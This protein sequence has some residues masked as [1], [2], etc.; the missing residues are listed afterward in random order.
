M[1]DQALRP[2]EAATTFV[3]V[4]RR[5]KAILIGS[6]GNL[7]EWYDFYSYTAFALY[8]A[9]AFFPNSDPVVQQLNAAVLFAATFLMRPLG[10]WLFGYV[11]DRYG[12]RLSLTLSV[13][14]MCF[15]SLIIAVT[16]TYATIGLAAPAILALARVIEGLSLGGEY[17]ASATYLT[18]VADAKHR[19]FYSSF[20]YV[21]LIGGQLTAIMV[22]L[23]LQKVFLTPDELKAWG[24]RIPFV[25]GALLAVFVAVM[26]RNL[27][28]TEA[29]VEAKKVAKPTGSILELLKYPR[30][31]LLVIG[32]T[33]GGTAAFY[34][35]TT[36]M[37]TFVKQS[38]GMTEDQTTM[39]VF[40]S[41]VFAIILQPI[42]GALSDRIGRK[43]VL[44]FF[45]VV[46]TL[47]TI[48]IL[49]SLKDTKSP[50]IAFLLICAAWVFTAGYTSINAVV[51]AEL[52]PTNVRALGVGV[53]YA[54]TVSIF[55]GTAPMIALYLKTMGHEDWF[56]YYLSG[57]IF[58]SLL[59]YTTMRDTKHASAMHR[60]Q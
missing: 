42:Y 58:L 60:H 14:C 36:Y 45:G 43:P 3:D 19:G 52:F 39:V 20:Q 6:A 29:F 21:T 35:F 55:G 23:L 2:A 25:I 48:P 50:L 54:L 44:I 59:I 26:R 41:L 7:V 56:Y 13:L 51:K 49:T 31:L 37:Q 11:A 10:G 4:E 32:L 38:V 34:T 24:W 8:F 1:T 40:G 46:G 9:P 33:A 47:A 53:P 15:G 27:H 5:I 57:V 28:E 30:E 12:R 17:G 16:P 22:L 18:E